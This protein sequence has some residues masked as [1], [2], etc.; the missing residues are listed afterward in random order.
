MSEKTSGDG[1]RCTVL[2]CSCD[3]YADLLPPFAELWGRFWPDCPFETVLV[4]ETDPHVAG[5]TKVIAC[6]GG[7]NWAGRLVKALDAVT[8]PYV[9]MLCDDY[10]LEKPVDTALMLRRL[11]EIE[12]F[13]AFNLRLIPNPKPT[14]SNSRPF[15]HDTDLLRYKPL[16]AYS[17][18]TQTGFWN[19]EFLR[20]LAVGK[21]SI[22]EFERFGSFDRQTEEKPLLV[23]PTKEFPFL[24]AVHKG[25]WEPWGL[26]VCREN[27]IDLSGVARTAPPFKVRMV[28]GLKGLVFAVFPWNWI[29]RVQNAFGLGA[30]ERGTPQTSA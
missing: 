29:V 5:F 15:G 18:A 9:M 23:T 10:Y 20:A 6:G 16:S 3:K 17:I 21:A 28:E 2:V 24:D 27:G 11:A 14:P 12:R 26:R 7:T 30:K 13:D 4:T 19:R 25:Y 1:A 8:T 22:W